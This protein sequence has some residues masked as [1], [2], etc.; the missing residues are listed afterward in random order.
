MHGSMGHEVKMK[1]IIISF[2]LLQVFS[3]SAMEPERQFGKNWPELKSGTTINTNFLQDRLD[4]LQWHCPGSFVFER[5]SKKRYETLSDEIK[6][7][8]APG[9]DGERL[10]TYVDTQFF[11][12]IPVIT[13]QVTYSKCF[14][15]LNNNGDLQYKFYSGVGIRSQSAWTPYADGAYAL[16]CIGATLAA[17]VVLYK[18]LGKNK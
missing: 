15:L 8:N 17:V 11:C 13:T 2:L 3:M 14:Q 18:L 4:Q 10:M 12:G 1:K 5:S 16:G 7:K 9:V 6:K